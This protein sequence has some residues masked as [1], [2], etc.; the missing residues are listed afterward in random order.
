MSLREVL[1]K[2]YQSELDSLLKAWRSSRKATDYVHTSLRDAL[3]EWMISNV[4]STFTIPRLPF[5]TMTI[6]AAVAAAREEVLKIV[7][8]TPSQPWTP[9]LELTVSGARDNLHSGKVS[10]FVAFDASIAQLLLHPAWRMATTFPTRITG[11]TCEV[12][13]KP[14]DA[15]RFKPLTKRS[16]LTWEMLHLQPLDKW[17]DV[18]ACIPSSPFTLSLLPGFVVLTSN[19]MVQQFEVD[20]SHT[21]L[22][23]SNAPC[24]ATL[25]TTGQRNEFHLTSYTTFAL[26]FVGEKF[27]TA[28]LDEEDEN[29]AFNALEKRN[30]GEAIDFRDHGN[31]LCLEL[32]PSGSRVLFD[33]MVVFETDEIM[34]AALGSPQDWFAVYLR[35]RTDHMA[36][37]SVVESRTRDDPIGN[38][39]I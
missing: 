31:V 20:P 18:K 38:A 12:G 4:P 27:E 36:G 25:V 9:L 19:S 39:Y 28:E 34:C 32:S 13:K 7:L 11:N 6:D 24:G 15:S 22:S 14:F 2:R 17:G 3:D 10:R 23:V 21:F 16:E 30:R 29:E 5:H 37:Q 8:D 35:G 33:D 26:R 1:V